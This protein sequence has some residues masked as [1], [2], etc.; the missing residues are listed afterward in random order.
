[1]SKNHTRKFLHAAI[2]HGDLMDA[3]SGP[4]LVSGL[5]HQGFGVERG[6][7]ARSDGAADVPRT[8]TRCRRVA[9]RDSLV[10]GSEREREEVG[11]GRAAWKAP[12]FSGEVMPFA[13]ATWSV[14][15]ELW[16]PTVQYIH[17]YTYSACSG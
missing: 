14:L 6:G 1:M 9:D 3:R 5:E 10:V 13:P 11:T 16:V 8:R 7:E 12:L 15:S 4:I 2:R 17:T